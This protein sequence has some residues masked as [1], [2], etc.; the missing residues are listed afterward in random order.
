MKPT[1]SAIGCGTWAWGN[2]LLWGYEPGMDEELQR[3]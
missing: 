3:V 2:R 1:F